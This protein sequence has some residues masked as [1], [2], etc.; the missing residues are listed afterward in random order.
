MNRKIILLVGGFSKSG[1]DVFADYFV[2][3]RGFKKLAFADILKTH[4]AN[5]F[6]FH[7][8]MA[9]TQTGKD[10]LIGDKTVR[11]LLIQE[12]NELK[13]NDPD[14]FAK[15]VL[16]QIKINYPTK[17]IVISDF[18]F[19]NELNIIRDSFSLDYRTNVLTT[20]I[21][22][23]FVKIG[24]DD[25]EHQL[26]NFKFDFEIDNNYSTISDFNDHI[27]KNIFCKFVI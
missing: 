27:S 14:V 10:S 25:S 19:K 8:S 9:Y 3:N 16:F 18:R 7:K 22:R 23:R 6:N 26:D 5:K 11:E 1:K 24:K 15:E 4:T 20:R 21:N 12:A 2:K 13:Q 17:N